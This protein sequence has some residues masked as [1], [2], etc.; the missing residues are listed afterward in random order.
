MFEKTI[1][2]T[3]PYSFF[4]YN[5][6]KLTGTVTEGFPVVFFWD[7]PAHRYL[8]PHHGHSGISMDVE[9]GEA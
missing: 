4:N 2:A 7:V 5:S 6:S 1:T 9:K 8:L 3:F